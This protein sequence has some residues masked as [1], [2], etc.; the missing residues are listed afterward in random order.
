MKK[1]AL[2]TARAVSGVKITSSGRDAL[3]EKLSANDASAFAE[4]TALAWSNSRQMRRRL[5]LDR[6]LSWAYLPLTDPLT[7]VT[8]ACSHLVRN[9]LL[10]YLEVRMRRNP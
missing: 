8:R 3:V 4:L 6:L 10:S 1:R 2:L 7:P 5:S 9:R